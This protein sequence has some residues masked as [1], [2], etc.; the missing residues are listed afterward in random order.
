M[1]K[2]SELIEI[3]PDR[4]SSGTVIWLHGLGASGDDFVP[5][6]REL[7]A[8]NLRF[9]F[10][11]APF[12]PV[13]ING[14]YVMRAWYDIISP[15]VDAHADEAGMKKAVDFVHRLITEEEHT[16]T[17]SEKIVL[18]GFSQGAVIALLTGLTY[19]KKL[20]GIL[21]LSGY[22]PQPDQTIH[23][24]TS[25]NQQTPIFLGHGTNDNIVPYQLSEKV[26]RILQE[27]NYP[28]ELH[29]YPMA[30][31]VCMNEISDIEE[32]LKK[33]LSPKIIRKTD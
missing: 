25:I 11:H 24:A 13:T 6:A 20:A 16:G 10:P 15:A 32:W 5:V 30:H 2:K 8:L 27:T 7:S 23:H 17:S 14:G 12:Q 31:S 33:I 1:T 9:V 3:N 22:L 26:F 29:S 21:A 19:P 18:A 28:V 4:P